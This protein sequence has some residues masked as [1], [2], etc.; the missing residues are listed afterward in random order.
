MCYCIKEVKYKTKSGQ[1]LQKSLVTLVRAI[2]ERRQ[3]EWKKNLETEKQ[4][5]FKKLAEKG[6]R[7]VQ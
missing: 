2:S 5:T 6:R 1:L 7:Q 3:I 4:P